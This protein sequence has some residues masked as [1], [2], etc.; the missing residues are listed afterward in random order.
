MVTDE[1]QVSGW[2]DARGRRRLRT[3]RAVC[4]TFVAA[5]RPPKAAGPETASFWARKA[6]DVG[7]EQ[8]L[9][10][11]LDHDLEPEDRDGL[12]QL[13]DALAAMRFAGLP[14]T[15]REGV[16]KGLAKTS[17]DA[18]A[19]V[20]ALRAL[21]IA[22]F[23]GY[24]DATG[25]HPGW[26]AMGYPGPPDILPGRTEPLISPLTVPAGQDELTLDADVCVVGSGSGGGVIAGVLAQ[27]GKDVVVL[28][29]GDHYEPHNFPRHELEAYRNMYWRGA[30]VATADRNV[31]L[32]AG[33][34][35]GGGA[36]I[37]W[38]NCLPPPAW[39]RE[40]WAREHG[41]D[42]LDGNDFDGH[43]DAVSKR[44]GVTRD[45][46]E[47]LGA[48]ARL[49]DGADALGWSWHGTARNTDPSTYDPETAGFMGYGDR[50]GSRQGIIETFLHDAASAGAR[51]LVR[52]AATRVLT[53]GDA[54]TGVEATHTRTDGST[55][56]VTVRARTVVVACGAL[57]TPAL[58]LRSGR[59]GPAVGR[60]LRLH[61]VPI[62]FGYYPESQR[63]WRG[64]P[65]AVVMDE[66]ANMRDGHGFLG[67]TPHYHSVLAANLMPWW[68]ARAHKV[69][70]GRGTHAVGLIGLVRERGGGR[71][72]IDENGR[73]VPEYPL[74]DEFDLRHMY[75]AHAALS[76]VHEAA[77]ATALVDP[78][79]AK[80]VWRKGQDLDAWLERAAEVPFG[81]GGRSVT[82]AHQMGTARMGRDPSASVADPEG[83]LH[84]TKG[85][86]IGDTSAFPSASGSNPMLT[87]MALA[88]RTAKA[89]LANG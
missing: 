75:A 23:Y 81:A 83:Q 9:A 29:A 48:D 20:D 56:R 70:V 66:F 21:T 50:S 46:S 34:T 3:L 65:Q 53:E 16:L 54:A 39:V 88:H 47:P 77:G 44:L 31:S 87:C 8:R 62:V 18:A 32:L 84:D 35:L 80:L 13:I 79:P 15:A 26:T 57:E 12:L 86:W 82:C 69:L 61:P 49:R 33:A 27:G 58:L 10:H 22:L 30:I 51:I 74:D 14:Q 42:G 24:L 4:D 45:C 38:T 43:L 85:V 1:Q 55:A 28:E 25:R 6:S 68:S 78:S 17:E 59:G 76:R 7:T 40:E 2:G 89:I 67:E 36:T 37:N 19:G 71:V 41:L 72:T 63:T 60:H 73:A 52:T 64:C 5:V 11:A